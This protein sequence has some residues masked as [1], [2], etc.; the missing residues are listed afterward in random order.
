MQRR[1]WARTRSAL[2]WWMGRT[3][4][5]TDLRQ[6]EG[7]LDAGEALVG[8]DGVVG[9]EAFGLD[10]GADDVDAVELLFGFELVLEACEGEG[11]VGDAGF[12][13]LGDL[14]AVDD[15]AD[16]DAD[17]V[18]AAEGAPLPTGGGCDG[19]EE[20]FG[21]GEQLLPLAAALDGEARI[22]ADDEPFAGEV[23]ALDFGEVPLVDQGGGAPFCRR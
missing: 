8:A 7:A 12:E 6:P 20:F 17:L 3:L 18:L 9:V 16:A 1:M 4:R 14:V 21:G 2:W 22:A 10:V 5:S 11:V 13:V 15:L 19:F 23:V